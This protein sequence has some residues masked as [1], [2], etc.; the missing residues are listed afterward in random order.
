V[1]R[2]L[3]FTV[4]ERVA[5]GEVIDHDPFIDDVEERPVDPHL[6]EAPVRWLGLSQGG[7]LTALR[8]RVAP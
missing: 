7:A 1:I 8:P 3:S 2:E 4:T 6:V 5:S